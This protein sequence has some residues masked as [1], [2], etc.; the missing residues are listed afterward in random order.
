[1]GHW[2]QQVQHN[3]LEVRRAVRHRQVNN[4]KP[5][6]GTM[7]PESVLT[8][9]DHWPLTE[10]SATKCWEGTY[11]EAVGQPSKEGE[12]DHCP[13]SRRARGPVSETSSE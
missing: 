13:K 3:R 10:C 1:M 6:V 11:Q 4:S 5:G 7:V 9:D 8:Q 2:V 12:G